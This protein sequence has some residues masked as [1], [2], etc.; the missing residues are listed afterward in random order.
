[1][2]CVAVIKEATQ[3]ASQRMAVEKWSNKDC[4]IGNVVQAYTF[5]INYPQQT[6]YTCNISMTNWINQQ[7]CIR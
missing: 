7:A 1:M 5:A 4:R 2:V 3:S 6:L